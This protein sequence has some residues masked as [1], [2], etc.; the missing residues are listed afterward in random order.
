MY[1][2]WKCAA[3][4]WI[5]FELPL[6]RLLSKHSRAAPAQ[7]EATSQGDPDSA[8]LSPAP[9]DPGTVAGLSKQIEELTSQNS[10]LALKV[11][12]R[13]GEVQIHKLI[14]NI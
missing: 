10:E 6:E 4:F 2:I 3:L 12:V 8:S 13:S 1:P 14:S 5:V 7:D 9:A 11:K